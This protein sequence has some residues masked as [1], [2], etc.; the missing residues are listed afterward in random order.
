MREQAE[1]WAKAQSL[2]QVA[3]AVYDPKITQTQDWQRLSPKELSARK[4]KP[5]L[6]N[7][8][9]S[10]FKAGLYKNK[11]GDLALAFAGTDFTS[12]KDLKANLRQG[13]GRPAKQFEQALNLSR[14][15]KEKIGDHAIVTGHS[16]GGGQAI[17]AGAVT[18]LQ[19]YT[20]NP[21]SVHKDTL[22]RERIDMEKAGAKAARTGQILNFVAK[23]EVL[24]IANGLSFV[25]SPIGKSMPLK[26]DTIK[27]DIFN[28]HRLG[29]VA[30]LID[31]RNAAIVKQSTTV[32]PLAEAKALLSKNETPASDTIKSDLAV[33]V[34][35]KD[36][37]IIK[38]S[39]SLLKAQ[40]LAPKMLDQLKLSG[41]QNLKVQ[42]FAGDSPVQEVSAVLKSAAREYNQRGLGKARGVK[43]KS[44]GR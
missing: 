35:N 2:V 29:H 9:R 36:D 5:E 33:A 14:I 26:S 37:R 19:T 20:F 10:G 38:Q 16:K 7:D 18:G 31:E 27:A 40:T 30:K 13:R 41:V 3:G 22:A 28:R 8:E 34:K 24:D 4:I 42:R 6:F 32:M 1:I 17:F 15:I 39:Q 23:G 43:P 21:S 44:H 12:S 11:R 25:P